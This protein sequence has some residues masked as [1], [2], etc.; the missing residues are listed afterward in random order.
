M[1]GVLTGIAA[2]ALIAC[3]QPSARAAKV[4]P[5]CAHAPRTQADLDRLARECPDIQAL[6]TVDARISDD[7]QFLEVTACRGQAC[8]DFVPYRVRLADVPRDRDGSLLV[9]VSGDLRGK[10]PLEITA[11]GDATP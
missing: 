3:G 5:A 9:R 6:A 2:A 10:T 7:G 11:K 4:P 1:R 8:G